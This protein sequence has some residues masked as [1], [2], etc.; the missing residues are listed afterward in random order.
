MNN[1]LDH[2]TERG[3]RHTKVRTTHCV[4]KSKLTA[5]DHRSSTIKTQTESSVTSLTFTN[6][7]CRKVFWV[8]GKN[9]ALVACLS[10]QITTLY[11]QTTLRKKSFYKAI[12]YP[13]KEIFPSFLIL[14]TYIDGETSAKQRET[15]FWRARLSGFL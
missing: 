9:T 4:W 13:E 1:A 7:T 5:Q 3:V 8:L 2:V 14:L 10:L 6:I 15:L 12:P 11:S